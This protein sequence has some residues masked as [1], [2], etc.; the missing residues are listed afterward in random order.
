MVRGGEGRLGEGWA[1]SIV[2]ELFP[3]DLSDVALA[4]SDHADLRRVNTIG[5]L[6]PT[7]LSDVALAKSDHADLRRVKTM[8]V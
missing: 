4:K 1:E 2:V 6:F 3:A 7:D 8:A 5:E